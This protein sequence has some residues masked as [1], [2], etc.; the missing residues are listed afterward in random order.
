[1][2]GHVGRRVLPVHVRRLDPALAA[3]G[4]TG[5]CGGGNYCPQSPVRRDQM[6]VF[7]LKAGH[8]SNYLPSDCAGTF[9]DVPCPSTFTN[10]I[11]QLAA[12]QITGGCGGGNYCPLSNNTRRQMAVFSTKMFN[13]Q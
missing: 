6:A 7:L 5:G 8:G 12:E 4:I 9:G 3:E 10:W 13:L 2:H 1:M 11:E